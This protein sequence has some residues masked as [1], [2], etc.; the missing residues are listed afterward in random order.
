MSKKVEAWLRLKAIS[1]MTKEEIEMIAKKSWKIVKT[2]SDEEIDE[3]ITHIPMI[4]GKLQYTKF[5]N[6]RK[7]K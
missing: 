3:V 7:K 4:Y 5:K 2:M 6:N 1:D